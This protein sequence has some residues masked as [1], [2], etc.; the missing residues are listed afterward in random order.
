MRKQ[1][2]KNTGFNIDDL[3]G[4]S[5]D[6]IMA[7]TKKGKPLMIMVSVSDNPTKDETERITALWQTSLFNANLEIQR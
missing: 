1:P 2:P 6:E 4:K 3:K 7:M 5:Q